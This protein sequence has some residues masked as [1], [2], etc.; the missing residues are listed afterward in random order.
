MSA[1]NT[2]SGFIARSGALTA[3]VLIRGH[4]RS[5]VVNP[6]TG[7]LESCEEEP[8][9]TCVIK[10]LVPRSKAKGVKKKYG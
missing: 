2:D 3:Y 4:H 6:R 9:V 8:T 1:D 7:H 10:R 5:F